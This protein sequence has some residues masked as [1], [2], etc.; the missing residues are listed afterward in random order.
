[1]ATWVHFSPKKNLLYYMEDSIEDS[2]ERWSA[3]PLPYYFGS[4]DTN[5][6]IIFKNVE[7]L[8]FFKFISPIKKLC[9]GKFSIF[10]NILLV[11]KPK[12]SKL[13]NYS[14]NMC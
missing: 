3:S 13:I 2:M 14:A 7:I 8:I 1:M 5:N 6:Y 11:K 9:K 12:I 10:N 4:F